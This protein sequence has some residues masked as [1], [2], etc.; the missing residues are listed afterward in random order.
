MTE[1]LKPDEVVKAKSKTI[2]SVVIEAFNS[3]IARNWNGYQ[4]TVLQKDVVAAL[5][6][7]LTPAIIYQNHYLD[8]ED[9]F[10]QAGWHVEYD[11]PGYN[12]SYDAYFVFRRKK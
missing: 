4:S 6:S 8:V 1:P 12:E 3:L 7:Q 9:L 11:K 5:S 10:R 2:P